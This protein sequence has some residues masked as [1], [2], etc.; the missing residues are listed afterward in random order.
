MDLQNFPVEGRSRALYPSIGLPLTTGH[1]GRGLTCDRWAIPSAPETHQ[2]WC[3]Q[4]LGGWLHRPWRG[5]RMRC[6]SIHFIVPSILASA[7]NSLTWLKSTFIDLL[8][9]LSPN[10]LTCTWLFKFSFDF[11]FFQSTFPCMLV[12]WSSPIRGPKF[13]VTNEMEQG[14]G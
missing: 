14:Q 12:K 5:I 4:H 10:N 9:Q 7:L 8:L 3:S 11:C 2:H 1:S 13:T 6:H